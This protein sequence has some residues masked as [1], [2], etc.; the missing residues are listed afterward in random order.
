ME[1]PNPM[2]AFFRYLNELDLIN[3]F[4]LVE[5]FLLLNDKLF[6]SQGKSGG[7]DQSPGSFPD[8]VYV[9]I[10]HLILGPFNPCHRT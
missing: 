3:L 8:L 2:I 1:A 5:M 10:I 4:M 6:S 9:F 7:N